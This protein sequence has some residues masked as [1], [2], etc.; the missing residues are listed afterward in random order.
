MEAAWGGALLLPWPSLIVNNQAPHIVSDQLLLN[1]MNLIS[2]FLRT[3]ASSSHPWQSVGVFLICWQ[4]NA[5][6]PCAYQGLRLKNRSE[7]TK[8]PF[9]KPPVDR[10]TSHLAIFSSA[11]CTDKCILS[12]SYLLNV[13]SG[14]SVGGKVHASLQRYTFR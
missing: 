11:S 14:W 5:T 1:S 2:H 8:R 6:G 7:C 13:K 12:P 9:N 10:S 4:Q 3:L